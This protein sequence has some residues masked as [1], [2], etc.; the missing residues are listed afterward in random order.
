MAG[1]IESTN[2]IVCCS[3]DFVFRSYLNSN[4]PYQCG[5][6]FVELLYAQLC[7]TAI[8]FIKST[9]FENEWK[10]CCMFDL[11]DNEAFEIIL[12]DSK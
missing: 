6:Y 9:S 5:F 4:I 7:A 11:C 3:L 1:L 8:H 10:L 12:K 2:A